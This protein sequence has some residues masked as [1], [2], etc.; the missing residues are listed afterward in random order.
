MSMFGLGESIQK[1][2]Q[3]QTS[4]GTSGLEKCLEATMLQVVPEILS[5]PSKMCYVGYSNSVW[6][7]V[8]M[9]DTK[10]GTSCNLT[11][12]HRL[13]AN[14]TLWHLPTCENGT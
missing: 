1:R 7:C 14:K 5:A 6:M 10:S 3:M 4:H 13:V 8:W 12:E 9:N 2:N 11:S